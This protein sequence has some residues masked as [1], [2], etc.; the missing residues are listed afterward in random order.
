MT[1][2]KRKRWTIRSETFNWRKY[3]RRDIIEEQGM[4]LLSF[5]FFDE[6]R[7]G[8]NEKEDEQ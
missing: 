8:M 1:Y 6:M 5:S 7:E 2:N 4:P 3:V